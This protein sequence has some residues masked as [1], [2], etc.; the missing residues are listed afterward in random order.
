MQI[1]NTGR[2]M[3]RKPTK[4]V[5][6][7]S[8]G[9]RPVALY[10]AKKP[11]SLGETYTLPDVVLEKIDLDNQLQDMTRDRNKINDGNLWGQI[12]TQQDPAYEI[13]NFYHFANLD[14][15]L[16][17]GTKPFHQSIANFCTE[18][19]CNIIADRIEK[20]EAALLDIHQEHPI[21]Y[22]GLTQKFMYYNLFDLLP[23]QLRIDI[24]QR[25]F[26]LPMFKDYDEVWI[27]CWGNALHQSQ[28]IG[29][30]HHGSN[31]PYAMYVVNMFLRGKQPSYTT[32]ETGD[33]YTPIQNEVGTLHI[34]DEHLQHEV[35]TNTHRQTRFTLAMDIHL[36]NPNDLENY[37]QRIRHVT[38][39][40]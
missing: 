29:I 40:Q 25:L 11:I 5:G 8:I 32:Y 15:Y 28:S 37:N 12:Q 22:K 7:F 33:G 35:K 2:T 1:P 21:G 34:I 24:Q 19:E 31:I 3:K 27:Q 13:D 38:R 17:M 39:I 23:D 26:H 9:G 14:Y 20:Y 36:N 18:T 16:E 30:H 6:N 4:P 10:D